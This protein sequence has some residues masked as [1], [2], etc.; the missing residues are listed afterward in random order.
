MDYT[1]LLKGPFVLRPC[2]SWQPSWEVSEE[3]RAGK[4]SGLMSAVRAERPRTV[5][6]AEVVGM[7]SWQGSGG[8]GGGSA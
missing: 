1:L 8:L 4:G 5:E 2:W 7:V 6:E 3:K